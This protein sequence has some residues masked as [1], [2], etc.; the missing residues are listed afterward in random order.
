MEALHAAVKTELCEDRL[1][2]G[3]GAEVPAAKHGHGWSVSVIKEELKMEINGDL[4]ETL[5]NVEIKAEMSTAAHGLAEEVDDVGRGRRVQPTRG[6]KRRA[7]S[8]AAL[9]S[10]SHSAHEEWSSTAPRRRRK[11]VR[12]TQDL[13]MTG[14]VGRLPPREEDVASWE[15]QLASLRAYKRR[16][17]DCNV[18]RSWPE[19]KRLGAWVHHQRRGKRLLDRGEPTRGMTAARVAKLDK[20]GF[21]WELSA[22][23]LSKQNSKSA[24]KDARWEAQLA[25]LKRYKCKNGDYNVPQ[26]WPEDPALGR[27]VKKQRDYKKGLIR[28]DPSKCN[29]LLTRGMAAARV[30]KLASLG[31]AWE[32]SA[33]E[34]SE[35][36][37]KACRDDAGWEAQLRKLEQYK[38]RH[39]DCNVPRSWA[40]DPALSIW[41]MAQ[42]GC[43]RKLDRGDRRPKITAA[44]VAKL[45][46]LGFA[47]KRR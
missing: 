37:G 32:L 12:V 19:D 5:V 14:V 34:L 18:P 41:V 39:G 16:H 21:A 38:W 9:D 1:P 43:K 15:R 28:S 35:R 13:V 11:A 6:T 40:E 25:K 10:G 33:A 23:E 22:S 46:A 31:F 3:G 26:S 45:D 4:K 8:Y 24:Q 27:W 47:W 7:V 44:R 29:P 17:G 42:R 36:N 30:A 2:M 20:V